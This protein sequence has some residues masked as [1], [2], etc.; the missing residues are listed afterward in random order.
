MP[1]IGPGSD[2]ERAAQEAFDRDVAEYVA[3]GMSRE[4]AVAQATIDGNQGNGGPLGVIDDISGASSR[5]ARVRARASEGTARR[6]DA[7]AMDAIGGL[8]SSAPTYEQEAVDPALEAYGKEDMLGDASMQGAG[9][10]PFAIEAQR[11]ALQAMQDVYTQGGMTAGDRARQQQ[12]QAQNAQRERASREAQMQQMAARGQLGGGN[13]VLARMSAAQGS[14][15]RNAQQGLGLE[16]MAEQRAL[17]AMQQT[18]TL[19]GQ[20]RRQSFDEDTARRRAAD[21]VARANW[22]ARQGVQMRNVASA[23]E[24]QYHNAGVYGDQ[25]GRRERSTAMRTGQYG[26][27]GDEARSRAEDERRRAREANAAGMGTLAT[28]GGAAIGGIGGALAGSAT[29]YD[30]KDG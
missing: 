6:A 15:D 7:G 17:A 30:E 14:A 24:G 9:A 12:M 5:R 3:Q 10:D 25:Y 27:R 20:V 21:E 1:M 28:I 16:A 26:Q 2:Q 8:E 22:A 23:R 18:G 13:E 4:D 29:D 19:G 11:R